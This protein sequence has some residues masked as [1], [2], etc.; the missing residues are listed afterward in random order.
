MCINMPYIECWC[1]EQSW[2]EIRMFFFIALLDG[3]LSRN[4]RFVIC[5]ASISNMFLKNPSCSNSFFKKGEAKTSL[6][7][8]IILSNFSDLTRPHPKR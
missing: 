7:V 2:L 1:I 6:Y 4:P 8:Y 3:K 5:G